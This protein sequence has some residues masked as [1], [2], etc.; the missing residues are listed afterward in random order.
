MKS[1]NNEDRVVI[2]EIIKII[3]TNENENVKLRIN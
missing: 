1:N 2:K 3:R